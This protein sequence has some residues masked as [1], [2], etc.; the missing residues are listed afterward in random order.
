MPPFCETHQQYYA[1]FDRRLCC[2]K[3]LQLDRVNDSRSLS[4]RY[5]T[6]T[7]PNAA[8]STTV[9]G[10]CFVLDS[11]SGKVLSPLCGGEEPAWRWAEIHVMHFGHLEL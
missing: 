2:S 1:F 7:Y 11:S 9:D 8:I 4:E 5:V 10:D 6:N 3:C